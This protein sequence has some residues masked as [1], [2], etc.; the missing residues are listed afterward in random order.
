MTRLHLFLLPLALV[1][2]CTTPDSPCRADAPVAVEELARQVDAAIERETLAGANAAVAPPSSDE[3]FLRRVWLDI[4]GDIPAP[5]DVIAFALDPA[6]DKRAAVVRGLLADEQYGVNWARY[7]RDVVFSR[8]VEDRALLAANAM[9]ADLSAQLNANRPWSEIAA[10]FITARG[11]VR[12]NGATAIIMAQD[13]RTEETTAEMARIFLGIQIQC[14]QCHDHP[15][16]EYRREEF[17]ELAAFFPRIAVRPVRSAA[18]RSFEVVVSDRPQRRGRGNNDRLPMPEHRMPDLGNPDAAGRQMQPKFFLTG[19]KMPFGTPDDERRGTLADWLTGNEW[20]A[21]ALVNRMW[22]ELVGEGFYTPIDDL[23]PG[24]TALAPTAAKLLS[25]QFVASGYD[26]KRLI[27]TICAT[28]AYQRESRPRRESDQPAFAANVPQPL[29]ADQLYNAITSALEIAEPAP[30][31]QEFRRPSGDATRRG[32]FNATFGFDPS[33]PRDEIVGS[34][35]QSLAL[36][37]SPQLAAAM[38]AD[39][40]TLLGQLEQQ[41]ESDEQM[42]AELYL[43]LL[44]RQPTVDELATTSAYFESVADRP[45]SVEDLAWALLNSAEFQHRR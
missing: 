30:R 15:Y 14:A 20:F 18:R 35:P 38:R 33:E 45:A 9:E 31:R 39:R 21:T 26:V 28:D 36:M 12:E 37:N 25:E 43:R 23:G 6:P 24:R 27:E 8:R 42:I 2:A 16:D 3:I 11:D 13:G 44:S 32:G 41:I 22:A 1:L 5:E 4:V 19:A 17:H 40:R 10:E 7:W 29:R 34:I